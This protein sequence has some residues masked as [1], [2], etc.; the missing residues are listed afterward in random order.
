MNE[1]P[2]PQGQLLPPSKEFRIGMERVQS[3][4]FKVSTRPSK[5]QTLQASTLATLED[6]QRKAQEAKAYRQKLLLQQQQQDS[7]QP[8][9]GG[10]TK[11]PQE[12]IVGKAT[13]AQCIFNMSNILMVRIAKVFDDF[14]QFVHLIGLDL[15]L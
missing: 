7:Q 13:F 14:M 12:K 11:K 1:S 3:L 5:K 4:D 6:E 15:F 8:T 10:M 9:A 2:R